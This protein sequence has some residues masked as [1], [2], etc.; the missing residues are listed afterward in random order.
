MNI[1]DI[2]QEDLQE[3]DDKTTEDDHHHFA[4]LR[5]V[6]QRKIRVPGCFF[7]VTFLLLSYC[8][9]CSLE[10]RVAWRKYDTRAFGLWRSV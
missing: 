2:E 3:H 7:F 5:S 10:P 8:K 1:Q 6:L 9:W 4:T